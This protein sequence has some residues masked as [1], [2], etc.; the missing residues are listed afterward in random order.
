MTPTKASRKM[1]ENRQVKIADLK[2]RLLESA[3]YLEGETPQ[4]V[5]VPEE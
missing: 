2:R 3:K 1:N 5:L 4:Q